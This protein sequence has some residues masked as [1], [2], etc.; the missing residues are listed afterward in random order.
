[1]SK[2]YFHGR[3]H[4]RSRWT[5]QKGRQK[6]FVHKVDRR[7]TVMLEYISS[8]QFLNALQTGFENMIKAVKEFSK[9]FRK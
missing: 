3:R 4:I 8:G 7:L 9:A 6:R 1:M 5:V 2:K